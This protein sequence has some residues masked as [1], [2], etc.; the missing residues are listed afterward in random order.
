[1]I[2]QDKRS[3][4]ALGFKFRNLPSDF[5]Y[6]HHLRKFKQMFSQAHDF[7]IPHGQFINI[8]GDQNHYYVA[9]SQTVAQQAGY[10]QGMTH[11]PTSTSKFTGREDILATLDLFF[12]SSLPNNS[13][14][15]Q[16]CFLLYGLG[17]A[18]KT[19]V[20][21][22]FQRRFKERFTKIYFITANT[23]DSIQASFYDI[24]MD[25]GVV[26]AQEWKNTSLP[27]I[28]EIL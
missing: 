24:A 7:T 25:N 16:K 10:Y 17:G 2:F 3:S 15:I 1:M 8:Q 11:C 23:E 6:H 20:A 22:E 13:R 26:D 9:E 5:K 4:E 19:Q 27:V 14:G 21:L 18:G 12:N 28:M